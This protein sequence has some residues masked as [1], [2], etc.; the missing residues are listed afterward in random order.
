MQTGFTG[1]SGPFLKHSYINM[2]CV[3]AEGRV[4]THVTKQR[5]FLKLAEYRTPLRMPHIVQ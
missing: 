4:L 3:S 5:L 2:Y 1:G